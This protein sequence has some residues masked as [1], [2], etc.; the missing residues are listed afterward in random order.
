[1]VL[2]AFYKASLQRD[3]S[4]DVQAHVGE[5]VYPALSHCSVR[6]AVMKVQIIKEWFINVI[7]CPRA[8]FINCIVQL[9]NN[10]LR[11]TL[12]NLQRS[13]VF[14][15]LDDL[16]SGGLDQVGVVGKLLRDTQIS[17]L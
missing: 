4:Q 15:H 12:L 16:L 5:L 8:D 7:N 13:D 2:L 9:Y 17:C 3:V 10:V 11:S 6:T 14:K 1:V